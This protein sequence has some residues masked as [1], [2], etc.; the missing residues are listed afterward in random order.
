LNEIIIRGDNKYGER[1]KFSQG[2]TEVYGHITTAKQPSTKS[3]GYSTLG[4]GEYADSIGRQVHIHE[5]VIPTTTSSS[6]PVEVDGYTTVGQSSFQNHD[7][8]VL[9][10]DR[11]TITSERSIQDHGY[12]DVIPTT[13]SGSNP[14][15]VDGYTITEQSSVQNHDSVETDEYTT[16]T[17]GFTQNYEYSN[18]I[19]TAASGA[20]RARGWCSVM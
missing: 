14:V 19:P 7:H 15:E 11:H 12:S 13:N 16:I 20:S 2:P 1:F 10:V 18:I 9:E 17:E 8:G 4:T 3:H 5:D 6:N